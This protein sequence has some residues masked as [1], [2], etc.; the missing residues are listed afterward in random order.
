MA[1]VAV[2]PVVPERIHVYRGHG[3]R[4]FPQHQLI[5]NAGDV[6]KMARQD[7]Q[8]V[9]VGHH[10]TRRKKLVDCEY[11]PALAPEQRQRLVNEAKKGAR[12][13]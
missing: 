7:G 10:F 4:Q 1:T 8:Q 11:H 13:N 5:R 9:G 3:K 12:K 2:D 6:H